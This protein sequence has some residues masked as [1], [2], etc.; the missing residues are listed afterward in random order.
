MRR[1]F[2]VLKSNKRLPLCSLK[3]I[4]LPHFTPCYVGFSCAIM[5]SRTWTWRF[6]IRR[7]LFHW[8]IGALGVLA[9]RQFLRGVGGPRW[10]LE[11]MDRGEWWS[12]WVQRKYGAPFFSSNSQVRRNHVG[13]QVVPRWF[14][15]QAAAVV[16]IVG[17]WQVQRPCDRSGSIV[18]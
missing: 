16:L 9:T 15:H 4:M 10:N 8:A 14:R 3:K 6:R 18:Y 17:I 13:W 1:S 7:V 2:E 5:P 11:W 12:F